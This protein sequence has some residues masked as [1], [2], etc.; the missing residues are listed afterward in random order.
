MPSRGKGHFLDLLATL[1]LK[2]ASTCLTFAAA[3]T[4]CWLM[5]LSSTST[6]PPT[7]STSKAGKSWAVPW[8]TTSFFLQLVDAVK[9][10]EEGREFAGASFTAPFFL[11]SP[12]ISV[13]C[14]E[15]PALWHMLQSLN[16]FQLEKEGGGKW[17]VGLLL[18]ETLKLKTSL[19]LWAEEVGACW[20]SADL[21]DRYR[22]CLG[23][24]FG[25]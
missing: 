1:W 10:E 9:L 2:Q 20:F 18:V 13:F 25:C 12:M 19:S 3:R 7:S 8:E 23:H 5:F 6:H 14:L 24:N 21:S 16:L 22:R 11:F 17:R 4:P 15:S